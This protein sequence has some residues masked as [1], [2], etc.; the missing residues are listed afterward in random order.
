VQSTRVD[1]PPSPLSR[2]LQIVRPT[3][4]TS[5][6]GNPVTNRLL[7]SLPDAQFQSLRPL[8]AF[9]SFPNHIN[10]HEQGQE[11]EYIHFLNWGLA[12]IVVATR[13]G[14]TVE[15]GVVGNEGLVGAAAV[16]GL[17][18]SPDRA[19]M[20]IGGS[21]FRVRVSALQ[22]A[23]SASP[24]LQ[25]AFNRHVAIQG[26]QAAQVAAC[27]RL[28]GVEQRLARRL[29]MMRD[30]T[31]QFSLQITHDSLSSILGTDRPS[32]TLA[33]GELQRKGAIEYRRGVVTIV[34]R[35]LLEEATCE[36]Y[37]VLERI[38]QLLGA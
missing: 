1:Q 32:V 10:L 9:Q 11:L 37:R 13:N 31:N 6:D 7:L 17:P 33:A 34:N 25:A 18:N 8:L 35:E 30:R 29:L 27:N 22:P 20:Q 36:C 16:V 28:H 3:G 5:W 26:M 15:V 21:G 2:D 23:L 14:K 12:S 38:N 19:V 24:H 4:R